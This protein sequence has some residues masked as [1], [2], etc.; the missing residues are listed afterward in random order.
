MYSNRYGIW[1]IAA[2]LAVLTFSCTNDNMVTQSSD[3]SLEKINN[4]LD[5]ISGDA[6]AISGRGENCEM[7]AL[8]QYGGYG[9]DS[10]IDKSYDFRDNY[11]AKSDKGKNYTN[12]YYEI[13]KYGIGNNL[14]SKHLKEHRELI[15]KSVK[16][17]YNLQHGNQ[18]NQILIDK[19]TYDD[20]KEML[21][22]YRNQPNHAEIDPILNYLETDLEKFF[23]KQKSVVVRDFQ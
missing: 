21:A 17:A 6:S 23:N 15:F 22:I 1:I 18:N 9:D 14:V 8:P 2:V 4:G 10:H 7:E 3:R 13:S 5:I 20:L 12:Y 11:L 19:E 16:I